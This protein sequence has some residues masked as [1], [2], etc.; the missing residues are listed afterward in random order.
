MNILTVVVFILSLIV[1][2]VVSLLIWAKQQRE[3][4]QLDWLEAVFV[5]VAGMVIL[6]GWIGV[7]LASFGVF[8][9]VAI[10]VI[11]FLFMGGLFWWK[12]PFWSFGGFGINHDIE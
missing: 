11:I 3:S 10:T 1:G 4:S 6:I 9:L 7:L 2:F 5:S 12:R 8:S